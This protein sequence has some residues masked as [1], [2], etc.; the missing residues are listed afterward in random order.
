MTNPVHILA[1]LRRE[2][3]PDLGERHYVALG[4]DAADLALQ[5]GLRSGAL[6]EVFAAEAG[7]EASAIGFAAALAARLS[8]G[9]PLLWIRQDFAALEFGELSAQG[10]LELGLNPAQLLLIKAADAMD[11]LK[12]TNEALSCASLGAV[13]AEI[14]GAP[15]VLDLTASRR[16]T[17]SAAA[18]AVTA[19]MLRPSA[20]PDPSA[21]ETRWLI[22]AAPSRL[23][24]DDW[25][26]ASFDAEL[27]RNRHGTTGRWVMEWS[28]DDGVF[29][30]IG[31]KKDTSA[32]VPAS[33]HRSYQEAHVLRSA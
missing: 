10:A 19:I 23:H 16:L 28:A 12:A 18:H 6:H 24:D 11:A 9:K 27:S 14:P 1:T 8:R 7:H 13:V 30:S 21:A 20:K 31:R 26:R 25:G 29:N 4:H 3:E 33:L 17:L 22:R 5:G 2:L 15:K 32:V